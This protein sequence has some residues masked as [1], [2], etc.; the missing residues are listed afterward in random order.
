MTYDL[1]FHDD[2]D[3]WASSAI[4]LLFLEGRGDRI[5]HFVPMDYNLQSQWLDESFFAKHHLFRGKRNAPI[6]LDFAFHPGTAF[7]FDHHPTAFKKET[8]QKKFHEDGSHMYRPRYFS[9]CH[10]VHAM[11]KRNFQWRPPAYLNEL[12][13]WLDVID[14]ARYTS[15]RQ[16][17][18]MA[19]PAF[20]ILSFIERHSSDPQRAEWLIRLLAKR[21]LGDVA[22]ISEIVTAGREAQKGTVANLAFYRKHLMTHGNTSVIDLTRHGAKALRFAPYYLLP[23]SHY[24]IWM[25]MKGDLYHLGVGA[26]PWLHKRGGAHIGKLLKK[27]GGGGHRK[28]AAVDFETREE[29]VRVREKIVEILNKD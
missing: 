1:Y 9:C 18:L 11:L 4:M 28:A 25:T 15:A 6:V 29:A 26:N 27:Y 10:M 3:G 24:S 20:A 7:W 22:K 17:I 14:A 13:A 21:S 19:E 8:W 12:I 5:G 16:T 2:F 23:K